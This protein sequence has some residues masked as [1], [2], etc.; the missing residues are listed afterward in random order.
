MK[1][2]S[3]FTPPTKLLPRQKQL[4]FT[5]SFWHGIGSSD[6]VLL[7]SQLAALP[8]PDTTGCIWWRK[9]FIPLGNSWV[10][11][12]P[13]SKVDVAYSFTVAYFWTCEFHPSSSA[14]LFELFILQSR[15]FV[16]YS[17]YLSAQCPWIIISFT[18]HITNTTEI[19]SY[20]CDVFQLLIHCSSENVTNRDWCD[21][22]LKVCRHL[23]LSHFEGVLFIKHCLSCSIHSLVR[24]TWSTDYLCTSLNKQAQCNGCHVRGSCHTP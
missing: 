21:R 22:G 10:R 8:H 2:F 9:A 3:L 7:S 6:K 5:G 17:T 4:D 16:R 1:W 15:Y 13:S 19:L 14:Y 24:P 12:V 18:H 11:N 20:Q 23:W